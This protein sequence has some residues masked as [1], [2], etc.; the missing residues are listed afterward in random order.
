V[1]AERLKVKGF[2]RN[3]FRLH[4]EEN[5]TTLPMSWMS[6]NN[7]FVHVFGYPLSYIEF[8]GTLTGLISVWLA[9]KANIWTWPVGLINVVSFFLIF[10]EIHLYADMFLQVY[11]FIT[12]LYG[13]VVWYNKS[14]DGEIAVLS[15]NRRTSLLIIIVLSTL[16]FGF[17]VSKIHLILPSVFSKPA[18]YPFPDTFLAVLSIIATILLAQKKLEN[19]I[20]WIIV[21]VI[22]VVLYAK[23]GVMVISVE[24]FVF[25]CLAV[26][27]L[28]SWI[29]IFIHEK[30]LSAG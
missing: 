27:G 16:I 17:I 9:A 18:S 3:L 26:V 28:V 12:S 10:F 8:L 29:K 30:R 21:D 13:W 6:I 24:Y 23:K 15:K 7:T 5:N 19:W 14:G 2:L 22:S 25:V 20:L 1:K 11:Y 4:D